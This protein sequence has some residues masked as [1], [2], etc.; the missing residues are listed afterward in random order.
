MKM[1]NPLQRKLYYYHQQTLI[2][3][4][5][6]LRILMSAEERTTAIKTKQAVT[7]RNVTIIMTTITVVRAGVSILVL[8][9]EPGLGEQGS[10]DRD[11][12]SEINSKAT[13]LD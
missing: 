9:H 4:T 11:R 6:A 7:T 8:G 3:G 10:G 2:Y 1:L 13:R 12:G 5:A